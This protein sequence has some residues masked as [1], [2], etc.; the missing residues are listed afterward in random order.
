M[1]A[2]FNSLAIS[3]CV[4]MPRT[5]FTHPR[6]ADCRTCFK[7]LISF[8][9]LIIALKISF[10]IYVSSFTNFSRFSISWQR[11]RGRFSSSGAFSS[12]DHISL[13]SPFLYYQLRKPAP[14]WSLATVGEATAAPKSSPEP[15]V[16]V[17]TLHVFSGKATLQDQLSL[18]VR[19]QR[20]DV[21]AVVDLLF[22]PHFWK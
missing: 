15:P 22:H 6:A 17:L 4:L 20:T 5:L 10:C 19:T 14:R 1:S 11:T 9:T 18:S 12:C 3:V 13:L 16:Q 2:S 21:D 7:V 8:Y